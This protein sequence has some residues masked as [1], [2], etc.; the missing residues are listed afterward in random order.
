MP[1]GPCSPLCSGHTRSTFSPPGSTEEIRTASNV[2]AVLLLIR[3]PASCGCVCLAANSLRHE[4]DVIAPLNVN[5]RPSDFDFGVNGSLGPRATGTVL[6]SD[7]GGAL[8]GAMGS[9]A[10]RSNRSLSVLEG[11]CGLSALA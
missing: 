3:P 4:N 2:L 7:L 9:P 11:S 6:Y 5:H 8:L 10:M 1:S